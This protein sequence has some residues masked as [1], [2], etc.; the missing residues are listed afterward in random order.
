M[1]VCVCDYVCVCV[2]VWSLSVLKGFWAVIV[3]RFHTGGGNECW[4]CEGPHYL[5]D[6]R[7]PSGPALGLHNKTFFII[8]YLMYCAWMHSKSSAATNSL[9][10]YKKA[11]L[12]RKKH[13]DL[14]FISK[15]LNSL[16]LFEKMV[17]LHTNDRMYSKGIFPECL[18]LLSMN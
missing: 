3:R 12:C 6:R 17:I 14:L 10:F 2:C 8:M 18:Y 5:Q 1:C 11:K 15:R 16:S 7:T 9:F 13:N 4:L